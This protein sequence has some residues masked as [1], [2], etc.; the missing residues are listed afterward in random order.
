[1][2]SSLLIPCAGL[3]T[4]FK[5]NKPKWAL[6]NPNGK[7]MLEESIKY[8]NLQNVKCIYIIFLKKHIEL[9]KIKDINNLNILKNINIPIKY[10]ILDKPTNSQSETIYKCI[11]HFKLTGPIFIK[12]SDNNFKCDIIN[13]NSIVGTNIKNVDEVHNKSFLQ[14]NSSN[15]IINIVEKKCISDIICIGGYSFENCKLFVKHYEFLKNQINS[16]LYISHIIY[17][18]LLKKETSF[19]L[20]ESNIYNDWGT[21]TMWRKYCSLYKTLFVDIDGTLF[22]SSGKHFTPKWGET[23][24]IKENINHINKLYETGKVQIILTTARTSEYREITINQLKKYNVK[25]DTIIFDLFHCKR[26]LINDFN[27]S[28]NSYPTAISINLKRNNNNLTD[29]L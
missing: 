14:I 23:E 2:K 15:K 16:E 7:L 10:Y 4:R 6:T 12:D 11:L 26:Y 1:M 20:I 19:Y 8:L 17:N 28:T 5:T 24:P 25:Y 18:I 22:I 9:L 27:P 21:H 13:S 3:S 29:F